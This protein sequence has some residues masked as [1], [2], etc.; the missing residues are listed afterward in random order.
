MGVCVCLCMC[1]CV[2]M[3]VFGVLGVGG[4]RG[5][6]MEE[7]GE[8]EG[9]Q[10]RKHGRESKLLDWMQV[11]FQEGCALQECTEIWFDELHPVDLPHCLWLRISA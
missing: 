8:G 9:G 5:W 3:H 1:V 7:R 11:C 2:G 10:W 4:K 6:G